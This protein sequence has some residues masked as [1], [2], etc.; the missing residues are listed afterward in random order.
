MSAAA[1]FDESRRRTVVDFPRE[2]TQG[3]TMTQKPTTLVAN[4]SLSTRSPPTTRPPASSQSGMT[5]STRGIQRAVRLEADGRM[6][7]SRGEAEE[8]ASMAAY[9]MRVGALVGD[10][11][12]MGDLCA[13]ESLAGDTRRL[14]Y[15]EKN[16]NIIGLE[17]SADIDLGAL[18][19]KLGL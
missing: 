1:A 16:G 9:V 2:R 10:Q 12:G 3:T 17:T 8:L 14:F 6:L 5:P 18:R 19:E 15:L 7:S 13:V 11:L 4:S